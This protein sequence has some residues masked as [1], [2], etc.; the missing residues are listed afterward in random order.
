MKRPGFTLTELVAVIA[1]VALIMG[2][3]VVLLAQ[4]FD[5]QRS[6]NA[7][8][9]RSRT[10]N[11]LAAAFRDDVRTYGKPEIRTEGNTL[12]R[13]TTETE[14]IEYTT[15]P[16]D[17]PDQQNIVR[18]VRREKIQPRGEKYKS[19]HYETYRLDQTALRFVEGKDDDAGLVALSL[20]VTPQGAEPPNLDALNPFDRTVSKNLAPLIDPKFAS[21]WRTIV[22]RY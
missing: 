17:F 5:F 3:A 1:V 11:H 2:T 9:E 4:L 6:N 18:T 19:K 10:V 12:L 20:W 14:T 21:H 16:G 22:A 15:E 13:W 8:A 7:Y